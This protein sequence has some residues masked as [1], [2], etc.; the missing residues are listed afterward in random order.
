MVSCG[1]PTNYEFLLNDCKIKATM[2]SNKKM[3][4]NFKYYYTPKLE[5]IIQYEMKNENDRWLLN[6]KQY[7][8]KESEEWTTDR[9]F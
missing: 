7:K 8:L 5:K 4:V 2:K 6:K 9:T 1:K 3:F